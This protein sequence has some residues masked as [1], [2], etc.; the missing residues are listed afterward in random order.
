MLFFPGLGE[1]MFVVPF[2]SSCPS[3]VPIEGAAQK[4]RATELMHGIFITG[5]VPWYLVA[6]VFN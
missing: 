2:L 3:I 6:I 1:E 4:S 5:L